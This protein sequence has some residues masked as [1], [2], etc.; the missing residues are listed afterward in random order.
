MCKRSLSSDP[1]LHCVT[2]NCSASRSKANCIMIVLPFYQGK[3]LWLWKICN[4]TK[5]LPEV[6][7]KRENPNKSSLLQNGK[8][9]I[10][11]LQAVSRQTAECIEGQNPLRTLGK[12]QS[13]KK[14][15]VLLALMSPHKQIT[16]DRLGAHLHRSFRMRQTS[17]DFRVMSN[18]AQKAAE[19]NQW[20]LENLI[21]NPSSLQKLQLTATGVIWY[22]DSEDV[23]MEA[24]PLQWAGADSYWA[25]MPWPVSV[26]QRRHPSWSLPAL[27]VPRCL[28]DAEVC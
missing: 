23:T 24:L 3:D 28:A 17:C 6:V 8:E 2:R 20:D 4:F 7:T 18:G 16:R 21:W 15:K 11:E 26:A 5:R 25:R 13:I 22:P 1:F 27:S 10:H 14:K 19:K 9:K 12:Y